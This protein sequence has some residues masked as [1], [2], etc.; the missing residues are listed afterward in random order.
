MSD[1][2]LAKPPLPWPL[3]AGCLL[4]WLINKTLS[5]TQYIG[6]GAFASGCD[7]TTAYVTGDRTASITVSI[8][9]PMAG[10]GTVNNLVDGGFGGNYTDAIAFGNGSSVTGNEIK[11]QFAASTKI[12]EAKF[13]MS[14]TSTQGTWKWQGSNDNSN[15]TD[16]GSSFSLGGATTQTQTQLNGNVN[17]YIYYRLLGISGTTTSVPWIYEFEFKQCTC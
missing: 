2:L 10:S 16:I 17:G 1:I 5:V 4:C 13:Y 7:C 3:G 6:F 11:F 14:D 15:W 9:H 8:T 12:D